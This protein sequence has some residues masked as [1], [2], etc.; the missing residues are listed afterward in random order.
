MSTGKKRTTAGATKPRRANTRQSKNSNTPREFNELELLV[1]KRLQTSLDI[2]TLLE[3]FKET[4]PKDL[5]LQ[6]VEFTPVFQP[7][8]KPHRSTKSHM[9]QLKL[10]A[11]KEYIGKLELSFSKKPSENQ[12]Q[13]L[14]QLASLLAFPLFHA[15]A[16]KDA[17]KHSEHDALTGLK[18][19]TAMDHA[20]A[21][22]CD[23]ARRYQYPL[24]MLM[25]DIDFFKKVNDTYGHLTGDKVL[26]QLASIL[27]QSCRLADQAFRYGGEEF[28]M[29]MQNTD[30]QG[31][32]ETAER[33]RKAIEINDFGEIIEDKDLPITISVG[34]T[35]L[36]PTDSAASI[37]SRADEAL[38]NAKHLGRNRCTLFTSH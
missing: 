10:Y 35:E 32:L 22:A 25:I 28:L 9:Q 21:K 19:R 24:G 15:I 37:M 34:V 23:G 14:E 11:G 29:L 36:S 33:I 4:I 8:E 7:V 16:F 38:Y 2:D 6:V 27:Q 30:A 18:N 5:H 1:C 17:I 13:L 3:H 20:I 12:S 26:Q 31:A